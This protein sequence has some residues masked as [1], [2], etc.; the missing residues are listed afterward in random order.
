MAL[1]TCTSDAPEILLFKA[2]EQG[3]AEA[4][5]QLLAAGP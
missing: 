1:S 2:V 3:D 5:E 4:V